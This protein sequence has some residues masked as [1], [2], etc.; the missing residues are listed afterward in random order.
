MSKWILIWYVIGEFAHGEIT[1]TDRAAC[2]TAAAQMKE[3]LNAGMSLAQR[4]VK[5]SCIEVR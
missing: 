2:I 5:T 3:E 1:F 4:L